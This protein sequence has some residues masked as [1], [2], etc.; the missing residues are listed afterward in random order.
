[1]AH[2]LPDTAIA[3]SNNGSNINVYFQVTDGS[4]VEHL[5][6][7][8]PGSDSASWIPNPD[9]VVKAGEA[10]FFTPLAAHVGFTKHFAPQRH[11]FFVDKKNYLREVYLSGEDNW[12]AGDLD[13]LQIEVAPYSQI[14]MVSSKLYY[15]KADGYIYTV[16]LSEGVWTRDSIAL[17][18]ANKPMLGCGI[19]AAS[20]EWFTQSN[21]LAIE[22][23]GSQTT[24]QSVLPS[25]SSHT[26]LAAV[27]DG[28]EYKCIFYTTNESKLHEC[29]ITKDGQQSTYIACV[30][31]RSYFAAI[32]QRPGDG[33][34]DV[35]SI[36]VQ[37]GQGNKISQYKYT[38]PKG[39][40]L[41]VDAI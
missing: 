8:I 16:T 31:P 11:V 29:R 35:I 4:I 25:P 1:M 21:S 40:Q 41:A 26:S 24:I 19:A 15:Q 39:W 14:A 3:A 36:F 38:Y 23:G 13:T 34:Q 27:G 2:T 32:R 7:F 12:T 37:T 33:H 30:P 6:R 28:T 9:P 5:Y 10:K 17:S 20:G 22:M 18:T